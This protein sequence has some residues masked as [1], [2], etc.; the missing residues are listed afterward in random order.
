MHNPNEGRKYLGVK[1]LSEIGGMMMEE[2]KDKR[3]G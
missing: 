2:K 1:N 3:E